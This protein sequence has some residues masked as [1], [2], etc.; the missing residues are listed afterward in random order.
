MGRIREWITEAREFLIWKSALEA[1]RRAWSAAPARARSG[2]LLAGLKL[3]RAQAWLRSRAADVEQPE[4]DFIA[5]SRRAA[6]WR[7]ARLWGMVATAPMSVGLV[8][9]IVWAGFVWWGVRQV[10]AAWAAKGEFVHIPAGCFQMGSPDEGPVHRV[11]IKA[12]ELA[13]SR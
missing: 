2:A 5:A 10:E 12:F 4:R 1:D 11:C 9:F 13:S 3:A 6:R 8:A 7:R